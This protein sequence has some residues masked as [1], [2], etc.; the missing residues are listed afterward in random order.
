VGVR[1]APDS[2]CFSAQS[3]TFPFR[4]TG[5]SIVHFSTLVL[6]A[7]VHLATFLGPTSFSSQTGQTNIQL[8]KGKLHLWM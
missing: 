3:F 6:S 4:K 8:W 5:K 2:L 7:A 1:P